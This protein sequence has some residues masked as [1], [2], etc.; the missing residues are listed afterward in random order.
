MGRRSRRCGRDWDGRLEDGRKE[1]PKRGVAVGG[2]RE[3]GRVGVVCVGG[4]GVRV[5]EAV[6]NPT[7]SEVTACPRGRE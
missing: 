6:L 4:R 1:G 7:S 3:G 2:G 5:G